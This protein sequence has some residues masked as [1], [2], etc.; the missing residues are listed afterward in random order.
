MISGQTLAT[1]TSFVGRRQITRRSSAPRELIISLR[2]GPPTY[3]LVI[4]VVHS[5]SWS[6]ASST[7]PVART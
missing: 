7:L 6:G 1:A 4:R 3:F 2:P 5:A